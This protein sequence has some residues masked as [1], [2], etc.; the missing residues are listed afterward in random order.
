MNNLKPYIIFAIIGLLFC[1]GLIVWGVIDSKTPQ[2]QDLKGE[3]GTLFIEGGSAV[4]GVAIPS[5][6]KPDTLGVIVE[7]VIQC[8]SKG[9]HY[10]EN[11][12]ILVGDLDKKYQ[13][14]GIGQYQ[15]RTF[16]FLSEKAGKELDW[17]SEADQRWLLRWS[18]ENDYGYL[19]SCFNWIT[20]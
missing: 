19:W 15:I 2:K 8:E 14:F 12:D 20:K 16:L 13:S 9:N 6:W 18:I 11:G 7:K 3:V 5:F 10:D 4:K 17:K 1:V